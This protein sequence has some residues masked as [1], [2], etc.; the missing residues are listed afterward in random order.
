MET[1]KVGARGHAVLTPVR[2]MQGY[3]SLDL[4]AGNGQLVIGIGSI[5]YEK[6]IKEVEHAQTDP[7]FN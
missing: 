4:Y 6:A 2:G 5:R 7:D 3:V 1:I